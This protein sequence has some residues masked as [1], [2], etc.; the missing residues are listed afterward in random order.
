MFVCGCA[1]LVCLRFLFFLFRLGGGFNGAPEAGPS[2]DG[3]VVDGSTSAGAELLGS[4]TELDSVGSES[5]RSTAAL[6]LTAEAGTFGLTAVSLTEAGTT[7][8]LTA[9]LSALD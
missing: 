3:L 1:V 8:C 5:F 6:G 9:A 7:T 2:G 4:T